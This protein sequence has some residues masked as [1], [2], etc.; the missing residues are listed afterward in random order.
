ILHQNSFIFLICIILIVSGLC[1]PG[2]QM[3]PGLNPMEH[4][5][6]QLNQGLNIVPHPPSDTAELYV[7]PMEEWNLIPQSNITRLERSMR[8]CCQAVIVLY[9]HNLL[10]SDYNLLV[11]FRFFVL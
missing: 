9:D 7:A 8:R 3:S 10:V 4:I 11:N 5:W 1:F 6:D 2:K